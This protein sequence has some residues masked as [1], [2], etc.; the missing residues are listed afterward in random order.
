MV[1]FIHS[2]TK[3]MFLKFWGSKSR[4]IKNPRQPSCIACHF[5][6]YLWLVTGWHYPLPTTR[7]FF[8]VFWWVYQQKTH[9]GF[10]YKMFLAFLHFFHNLSSDSVCGVAHHVLM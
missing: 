8:L 6:S 1:I 5:T 7:F 3:K 10:F 4:N 2:K 9:C